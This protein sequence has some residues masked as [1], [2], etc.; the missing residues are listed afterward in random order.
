MIMFEREHGGV[1]Y[2]ILEARAELDAK[3]VPTRVYSGPG[4]S[5]LVPDYCVDDA[6]ALLNGNP[7]YR[8]LLRVR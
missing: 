5:L 3:G 2:A 4:C 7:T 1:P 6:A 8:P